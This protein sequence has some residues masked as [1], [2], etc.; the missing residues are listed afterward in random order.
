MRIGG[1]LLNGKI[2]SIAIDGPAG[3]GKSTISKLVA[4]RLGFEYIDTGSM[5]RAIALKV[6][7]DN[8]D[9]SNS[10]SIKQLV[11]NTKL[12]FVCGDIFLDDKNVSLDIRKPEISLEAS[13]IATNPIIR[14]F[15]LE[16]QREIAKNKSVV[17]DGRDIGTVVL[18]RANYKFFLTASIDERAMRR[19]KELD[20][21]SEIL[22]EDVKN[23]II[24][25]DYNDM[26][27]DIAPLKQAKE[28]IL[29]DSTSMSIGDTVDEIVSHIR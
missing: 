19:F 22:Y 29:I 14:D 3:A 8:I 24:K 13:K 18:P 7:I 12:D 9:I 15:L 5:F 20:L 1:V 23:D 2:V 26:N 27:R 4:K 11:N 6:L 16:L 10:T 28:A 21:N 25:R 17:M